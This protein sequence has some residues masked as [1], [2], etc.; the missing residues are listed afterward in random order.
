[1]L[2]VKLLSAFAKAPSMGSI[3]AAGADI[4]SAYAYIVKGRSRQLCKTDISI[5]LP[6]GTYGRL[7]SRSGLSAKHGIEVGAGVIDQDYEGPLGVILHNHSDIDFKVDPGDRIAQLI[8]EK[9][10]KIECIVTEDHLKNSNAV[11]T[12]ESV[13]QKPRGAQGYG[14]TGTQ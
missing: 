5:V 14:S 3:G 9:Y 8:L 12:S 7:A 1:M 6:E 13:N 2:K 10:E 4:R 11:F